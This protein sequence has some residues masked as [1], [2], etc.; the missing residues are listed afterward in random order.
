MT[1]TEELLFRCNS[2]AYRITELEKE[3][4]ADEARMQETIAAVRKRAEHAESRAAKLIELFE[5][6]ASNRSCYIEHGM[7]CDAPRGI[8]RCN[9]G[10][11]ELL[12]LVEESNNHA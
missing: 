10:Q 1:E 6:G 2:Y 8:G 7:L 4:A 9:C 3:R 12:R 11:A 5:F